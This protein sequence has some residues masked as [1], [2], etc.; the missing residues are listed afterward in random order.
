MDDF[1]DALRFVEPSALR[2]VLIETP[3]VTWEDIGGL[4]EL[5]QELIEAIEW[6]LKYAKHF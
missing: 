6:P 3:N 2:E 5:K 1:Q 4:H